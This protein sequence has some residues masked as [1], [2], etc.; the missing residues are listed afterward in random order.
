M[1]REYG[2]VVA[3]THFPERTSP[4]F[5][6][7]SIGTNKYGE[8]VFAKCDFIICGQETIGA[9]ERETDIK[10]MRE[11]F[12]N[13]SD[14]QYASQLFELFGEERVESELEDFFKLEM[15]TRWGFGMGV[16]RLERAMKLKGLK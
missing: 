3:I 6:M 7:K 11:M 16:T 2:D 5:N 1:W 13:I 15:I 12:Y 14:G 10:K 4:F 9:A 8:K